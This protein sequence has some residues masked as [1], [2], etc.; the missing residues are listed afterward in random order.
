MRKLSLFL[1]APLLAHPSTQSEAKHHPAG[2]PTSIKT[3]ASYGIGPRTLAL[4]KDNGRQDMSFRVLSFEK[5]DFIPPGVSAGKGVLYE[6]HGA[7]Y[8]PQAGATWTRMGGDPSSVMG[9]L[10]VTTDALEMTLDHGKTWI[11]GEK[12]DANWRFA[13]DSAFITLEQLD[14]SFKPTSFKVQAFE[15]GPVVKGTGS[16]GDYFNGE[17]VMSYSSAVVAIA[18][19][20]NEFQGIL[21]YPG[22]TFV[23]P[24]HGV[25]FGDKWVGASMDASILPVNKVRDATDHNRWI[26]G[27]TYTLGTFRKT[28][29]IDLDASRLLIGT[30][31]INYGTDGD[32]TDQMETADSYDLTSAKDLPTMTSAFQS[33][34]SHPVWA[35]SD[36][37]DSF[38]RS[39]EKAYAEAGLT[40]W[41]W[42]PYAASYDYNN[43]NRSQAMSVLN[44]MV[45]RVK[46]FGGGVGLLDPAGNPGGQ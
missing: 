34:W 35:K 23:V 11:A 21:K 26:K 15:R 29:D 42:A 33:N 30:G 1:C 3:L 18:Y 4:W 19:G 12:D 24:I 40:T 13:F 43:Q 2:H 22:T 46:G 6:I 16:V 9:Y 41:F 38:S 37:P 31:A 14:A 20:K 8:F 32:P 27:A 5:P 44:P 45:A 17:I 36:E 7:N 39:A 10:R 28:L 25:K